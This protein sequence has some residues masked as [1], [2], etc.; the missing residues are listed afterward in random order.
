VS[1]LARRGIRLGS[2][3]LGLALMLSSKGLALELIGG[4][5]V[6]IGVFLIFKW[7]PLP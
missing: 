5:L 4:A 3:I 6:L 2:L 1:P 7:G